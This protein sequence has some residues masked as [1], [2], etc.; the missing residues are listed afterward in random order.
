[1]KDISKSDTFK[2]K[3]GL[4]ILSASK[5]KAPQKI[6]IAASQNNQRS[7]PSPKSPPLKLLLLKLLLLK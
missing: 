1:M 2:L 5:E 6:K 4:I 3:D 7:Y